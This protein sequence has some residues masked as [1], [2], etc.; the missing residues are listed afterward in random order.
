VRSSAP[1]FG[2]A[3]FRYFARGR[4]R[5][6]IDRSTEFVS[7]VHRDL[8]GMGL[9]P[10]RGSNSERLDPEPAPPGHLLACAVQFSMVGSAERDREFVTDFL[11]K[12]TRL[13]KPQVV[14]IGGLAAAD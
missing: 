12:P 2:L 7:V 9:F 8:A 13:R 6:T 11:R 10:E 4:G 3:P 5:D 14:R 1:R